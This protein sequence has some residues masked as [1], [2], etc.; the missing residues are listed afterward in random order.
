MSFKPLFRF[1]IIALLGGAWLL[2]NTNQVT[3]AAA[4]LVADYRFNNSRASSVG[5][6]PA[7]VDLGAN[8]FASETVDA[9]TCNVLTFAQGSGLALATNG[10]IAADTYSLVILFRFET[11]SGYRKIVD[12]KNGTEDYGLYNLSQYLRFYTDASGVNQVFQD[13]AY[14]QVV[15][16]RDGATKQVT[17]YVDGAQEIQFTDTNDRALIDA[18]NTLRFFIDDTITGGGEASAGAVARLRVYDDVLTPG[19]VSALDRTHGDCGGPSVITIQNNDAAVTYQNWQGVNDAGASGGSYRQNKN[20]GGKALIK[21]SGTEVKYFYRAAPNMGKVDVYIDG[22]KKQTL[23]LYAASPA[24]KNKTFKNLASGKHKLEIRVL[25]QT[26]KSGTDT[27]VSIDKIV[28][29]AT[30]REDDALQWSWNGW[31]GKANST[32]NGGSYHFSKTNGASVAFTFHGAGIE[33]LTLKGPAFG[34]MDVTIDG[35]FIETLN[36]SNATLTPF[37][38]NYGGLTNADHTIVLNRNAG[39]GSNSI[40][41]DGFR[42][43]ITLP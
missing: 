4:S 6:A 18:N 17:G 26:C 11:T 39:S 36:L 19:E 20:A 41:I 2:A 40:V 37:T 34:Q 42:G 7:L 28:A 16:T 3:R 29:G 35:A 22:V 1:F 10:L 43:P 33:V 24:F 9:T 12:F 30:T 32:A 15:L 21:F 13:N 14:A 25:N 8:S 23:C 5:S 38:K 27:Y 31:K